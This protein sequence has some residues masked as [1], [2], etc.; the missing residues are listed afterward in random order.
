MV[1]VIFP[2]RLGVAGNAFHG[3]PPDRFLWARVAAAKVRD[4]NGEARQPL[5]SR[6]RTSKPSTL[7]AFGSGKSHR[8]GRQNQRPVSET[9]VL[10]FSFELTL[11]FRSLCYRCG[12][13]SEPVNGFRLSSRKLTG[14]ASPQWACSMAPAKYI[15]REQAEDEC[16][17]TPPVK[18]PRNMIGKGAR[19]SPART[20][21]MASTSSSPKDVSRRVG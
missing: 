16:R 13:H 2:D 5:L 19:Y 12:L 9:T 6:G 18:S 11:N 21:R 15:W 14:A 1:T 7:S 3:S 8:R 20:M 4:G 10:L 17:G